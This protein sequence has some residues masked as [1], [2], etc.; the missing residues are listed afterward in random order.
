MDNTSNYLQ[1]EVDSI[2]AKIE[3]AKAIIY[4]EL[5]ISIHEGVDGDGLTYAENL[6]IERE[7]R[8]E[9]EEYDEDEDEEETI[10]DYS[11]VD[12][13]SKIKQQNYIEET[14]DHNEQDYASGGSCSRNYQN[15][16]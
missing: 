3:Q 10:E 4:K 9:E 1:K 13:I 12:E 16:F 6:M 7:I 11:N 14:N 2:D 5:G 8:E 15:N